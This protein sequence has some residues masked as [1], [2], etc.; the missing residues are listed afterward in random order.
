MYAIQS[1]S[2]NFR[3]ARSSPLHAKRYVVL[4]W[5]LM[6]IPAWSIQEKGG[7]GGVRAPT[8]TSP[9]VGRGTHAGGTA[10]KSPALV[11]LRI[12]VPP[13]CAIW[14][15]GQ[16]IAQRDHQK[17][18]QLKDQR[19]RIEY[20]DADDTIILKSLKPAS[21]T[22]T[23]SKPDHR[24]YKE[25][26]TVSERQQNFVTVTLR[27][28]PGHL[29]VATSVSGASIEIVNL[30][31]SIRSGPYIAPL[32]HA[33][34]SPGRYQ[35]NVSKDGYTAS[36]REITIKA[37]ES[38]YLEPQL[39]PIPAPTPTPMPTPS[40]RAP[41]AT[42]PLSSS[43]EIAGK[44]LFITLRGASGDTGKTVGSIN[45]SITGRTLIEANGRLNGLPC[46]VQFVQLE[47]V[48]EGSLIE[49]PGPSNQWTL[50]IVRVRP[51]DPKRPIRFAINWQSL[52]RSDGSTAATSD[53]VVPAEPV[54]KVV[55]IFPADGK[56]FGVTGT[57]TVVCL[58]D[59][60]GNVTSAKAVDGPNLLRKAAEDAARQ[61]KFRPETRNNNSVES[62][63][64]LR[65]AFEKP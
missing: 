36:S 6:V 16:E 53:T 30:E 9:R 7:R 20:S 47:N 65:F 4:V 49:A 11:D 32:D 64:T 45:V 12:A 3:K 15:D 61:W 38:I 54:R 40:R 10:R 29:T 23:A 27:P 44:E 50:L 33:E 25:T 60:S 34:F 13:D 41:T 43:V 63:V 42:V 31:S 2:L 55:P 18:L 52:Q 28:E 59:R 22:I 26:V 62:T 46:R 5:L 21:Y 35:V 58:V 48:S 17:M 39:E 1:P 57:V 56:K 8:T 24:E 37:S 19:I 51:K 14:L